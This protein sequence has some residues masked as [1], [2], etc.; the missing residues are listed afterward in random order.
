ML[1]A[2]RRSDVV[3][4]ST[5]ESE[6]LVPKTSLRR[7]RWWWTRCGSQRS[8][9]GRSVRSGVSAVQHQKGRFPR[10]RTVHDFRNYDQQV[11]EQR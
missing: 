7:D 3:V 1:P 2:D 9:T 10:S 6:G 11:N 4:V 5:R 8:S